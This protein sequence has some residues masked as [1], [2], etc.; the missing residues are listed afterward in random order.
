MSWKDIDIRISPYG[1]IVEKIV[2]AN[3]IFNFYIY[4]N[5]PVQGDPFPSTLTIQ[6]YN[7]VKLVSQGDTLTPSTPTPVGNWQLVFPRLN[8]YKLVAAGVQEGVYNSEVKLRRLIPVAGE[9]V[10]TVT[11]VLDSTGH[12]INQ[13]IVLFDST[14]SGTKMKVYNKETGQFETV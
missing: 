12:N 8:Q 5:N 9:D 4:T 14:G 7:L 2:N 11:N 6:E 3:N 13:K 1:G 10:G